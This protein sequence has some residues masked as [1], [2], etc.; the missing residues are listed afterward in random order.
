MFLWLISNLKRQ[1][2]KSIVV[3]AAFLEQAKPSRKRCLGRLDVKD[4]K[5]LV[6][7]DVCKCRRELTVK[8]YTVIDSQWITPGY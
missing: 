7:N 2:D 3:L 4:N 1:I 6:V 8:G 5:I